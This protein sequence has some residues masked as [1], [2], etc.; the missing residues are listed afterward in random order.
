MWTATGNTRGNCLNH[1]T[2]WRVQVLAAQQMR[3]V[4]GATIEA[5]DE[6]IGGDAMSLVQV[7]YRRMAPGQ[8]VQLTTDDDAGDDGFNRVPGCPDD[9]W[10]AFLQEQP[11][12]P[13]V[14]GPGAGLQ[15][16]AEMD[17]GGTGEVAYEGYEYTLNPR[18]LNPGFQEGPNRSQKCMAL[19]LR[20]CV[21]AGCANAPDQCTFK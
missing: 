15:P 1:L 8:L 11:N 13:G 10:E 20:F 2:F 21:F 14:Q 17:V 18:F 4:M 6:D 16:E 5:V 19:F 3:E 7:R 9:D 12:E